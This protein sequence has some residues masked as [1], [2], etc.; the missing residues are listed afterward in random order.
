MGSHF[1]RPPS[2]GGSGLVINEGSV[3]AYSRKR[4]ETVIQKVKYA[5]AGFSYS[6]ELLT[7]GTHSVTVNMRATTASAP[8]WAVLGVFAAYPTIVFIRGPLRRRRRHRKGL[9][10][11]CSYDLTGN[12]SGVCPECGKGI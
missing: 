5:W 8:I 3:E 1:P 6:D 4:C 7:P 9:C 12:E 11:K 10:I 2:F